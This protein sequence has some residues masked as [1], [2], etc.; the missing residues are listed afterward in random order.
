[1]SEDKTWKK[2]QNDLVIISDTSDCE[3]MK[4][5]KTGKT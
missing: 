5:I 3:E 2:E 4:V 1:M